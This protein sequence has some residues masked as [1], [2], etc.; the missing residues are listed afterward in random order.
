MSHLAEWYTQKEPQLKSYYF[1]AQGTLGEQWGTN[2]R[3]LANPFK[4][5]FLRLKVTLH[6][7]R[8]T[9][10]ME[11]WFLSVAKRN[12]CFAFAI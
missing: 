1:C 3:Q 6:Y 7:W 12:S 8:L 2:L 9:V 10:N 4:K 5:T 11:N